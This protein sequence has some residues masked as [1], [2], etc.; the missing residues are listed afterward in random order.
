VVGCGSDGRRVGSAA[1]PGCQTRDS[2]VAACGSLGGPG[3]DLHLQCT[4]DALALRTGGLW[5]FE[6]QREENPRVS[7]ERAGCG[8]A[9]G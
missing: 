7:G 4:P 5:V 2:L 9:S 3:E 8:C 1:S 6:R